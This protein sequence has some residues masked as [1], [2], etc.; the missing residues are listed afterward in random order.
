M[1]SAE[2]FRTFADE[3][4]GWAKTAKSARERAI[5]LQMAETWLVAAG[6]IESGRPTFDVSQFPV[7]AR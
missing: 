5:F 2:E 4:M 6:Q 1:E 3:C 7:S